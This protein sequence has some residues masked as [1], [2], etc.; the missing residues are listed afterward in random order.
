MSKAC[1]FK[2]IHIARKRE[3]KKREK[4]SPRCIGELAERD[5]DKALK[6]DLSS[7][8]RFRVIT[9]LG[10]IFLRVWLGSCLVRLPVVRSPVHAY[11]AI[12]SPMHWR[13]LGHGGRL[14]RPKL[15][16]LK[17]RE[18]RKNIYIYR[19]MWMYVQR[20]R[21]LRGGITMIYT[22]IKKYSMQ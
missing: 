13:G 15:H 6:F 3:S 20:K 16:F 5:R 2:Y 17:K 1:T 4:R 14:E 9:F 19:Y 8:V 22:L 10:E 12:Y 7:Q 21:V 18:K 11:P